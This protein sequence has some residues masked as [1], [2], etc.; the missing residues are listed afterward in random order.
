MARPWAS[1]RPATTSLARCFPTRGRVH[2]SIAAS[3]SA[4]GSYA[5]TVLAVPVEPVTAITIGQAVT[6]TIDAVGE[7]RDYTFSAT[8]GQVVNITAQATCATNPLELATGGAR[9]CRA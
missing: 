7:I 2:V 6:G 5:F 4:T 1:P 8:T 3:G 9:R